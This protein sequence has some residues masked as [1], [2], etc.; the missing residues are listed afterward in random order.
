MANRLWVATRK[1]LFR[2]DRINGIWRLDAPSFLGDRVSY[3]LTDAR[4]NAI[5]AALDL[6]HFGVKLHRSEDAGRHWQELTVPNHSRQK[7]EGLSVSLLWCFATG[8]GEQPGRLWAG[9]I[10]GGLFCSD[11]RGARW[12][13]VEG[14]WNLPDRAEWQ[15]GGYD[16]PG[17]HSICVDPQDGTR[18]TVGV[19]IGGVWHSED[20]GKTWLTRSHG[21][22]AEYVPPALAGENNH[23]DPHALRQAPSDPDTLWCQHH[24]GIFVSRN[25]GKL[26]TELKDVK[27]SVFG[28]ALAVHPQDPETAWFVPAVKDETRVP[29]GGG[30]V[31]NR[32]RDGGRRFESLSDGL[33]QS[34]C[35][36]LVY[37]H[38][39][40]VDE[41]GQQ[42]AMGSTTGSLWISE[43]AGDSWQHLSSHL[44]PVY[45]LRF[46]RD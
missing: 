46:E 18:L 41:S 33:P 10:P 36:D 7:I 42:L 19:S 21:M 15:G 5:Y 20:D 26:W 24:N 16:S 25:G 14:L 13:L 37:R 35:Y 22:R 39:L 8:T 30:L 9:T 44:P 12:K 27:P 29:V 32:T 38:G 45:A 40:D 17:V 4:D 28:F 6:G 1:G 34:D 31:V 23:Q 3:V 11:D 43:N 2:L